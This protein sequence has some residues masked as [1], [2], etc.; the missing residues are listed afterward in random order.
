[1]SSAVLCTFD[2]YRLRSN[3]DELVALSIVIIYQV[4]AHATQCMQSKDVASLLSAA[5]SHSPAAQVCDCLS[6]IAC[7][8]NACAHLKQVT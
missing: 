6:S 1:M 8:H 2:G 7:H 5:D 3:P 4:Q